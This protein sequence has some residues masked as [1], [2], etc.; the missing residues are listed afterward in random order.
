[1]TL[2]PHPRAP[3]ASPPRSPSPAVILKPF[4]HSLLR[5]LEASR[6]L[7]DVPRPAP[8]VQKGLV[9]GYYGFDCFSDFSKTAGRR[10]LQPSQATSWPVCGQLLYPSFILELPFV[11]L[12][13]FYHPVPRAA[14]SRLLRI[15]LTNIAPSAETSF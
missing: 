6:G 12:F 7:V 15:I 14:R 2:P 5:R 3:P 10:A 13:F 4:Q 1:M 8:G 11:S 9:C